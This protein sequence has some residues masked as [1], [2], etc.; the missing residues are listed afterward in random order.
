[1]LIKN[2]HDME[3][4]VASNNSLRWEGWDIINLIEDDLAEYSVDGCFDRVTGRW[5]KKSIYSITENGWE[6][7]E[8]VI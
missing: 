1:M 7:P 4:I 3:N 2:L 5:Y 6:I 8:S